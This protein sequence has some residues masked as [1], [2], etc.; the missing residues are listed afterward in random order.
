MNR[1]TLKEKEEVKVRPPRNYEV[2]KTVPGLKH[3]VQVDTDVK[4]QGVSE[5]KDELKVDEHAQVGQRQVKKDYE[6]KG[7][8][9][10]PVLEVKKTHVQEGVQKEFVG[11]KQQGQPDY[12]VE[13]KK[14]P[15]QEQQHELN[16]NKEK[17]KP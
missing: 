15:E 3:S 14:L 6:V 10:P 16:V 8:N 9:S 7:G 5:L 1:A 11:E 17:Q 4:V 13:I 2:A 12:E